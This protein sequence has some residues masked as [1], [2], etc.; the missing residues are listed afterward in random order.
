VRY[1][2]SAEKVPHHDDLIA[3]RVQDKS[4][5]WFDYADVPKACRVQDCCVILAVL[6]KVRLNSTALAGPNN[7]KL[8]DDKLLASLFGSTFTFHGSVEEPL[9]LGDE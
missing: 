9:E 4:N 2:V 8:A 7:K 3:L 5:R 6:L 1:S